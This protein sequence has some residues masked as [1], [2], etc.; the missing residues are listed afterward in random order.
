M[1]LKVEIINGVQVVVI[2]DQGGWDASFNDEVSKSINGAIDQGLGIVLDMDG[3]RSLN[4]CVFGSIVMW[5]SRAIA[6][7]RNLVLC[8]LP[9]QTKKAL[10]T[11]RLHLI[12]EVFP[13][14]ST[15]VQR[16]KEGGR[17]DS[18]RQTRY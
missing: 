1:S 2:S 4:S 16:V 13:D 14:Q 6:K 8:R 17:L 18:G 12:L 5:R 15:A 3:V 11:M 7:G 9:E 10:E